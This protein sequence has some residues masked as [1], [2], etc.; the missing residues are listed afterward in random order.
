MARRPHLVPR[1]KPLQRRA[2]QTVAAILEAAAQVFERLGYARATTDRIA[3]R[4]GVSIGSLYQYFPGK[5]AILVALLEA[6]VDESLQLVRRLL[7]RVPS[8][9]GLHEV[10]LDELVGWFLEDLIAHH[11][12]RPRLQRLLLAETPVPDKAL[13]HLQKSE[14]EIASLVAALLE[15]HPEV[16]VENT[17]LAAWMLVHVTENLVHEYVVHPPPGPVSEEVFVAE[18]TRLIRAW[19]T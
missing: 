10:G 6:H 17:A 12:E 5:D 18:T 4:A 3:E 19:L 9:K 8:G 16:R 14:D 11:R 7:E 1:K 2:Q 13:A 15:N